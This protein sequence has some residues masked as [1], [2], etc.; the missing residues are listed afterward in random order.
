[1]RK[2][3]L[4]K[5]NPEVSSMEETGTHADDKRHPDGGAGA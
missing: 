5:G 1:M 2:R 3:K 4:G